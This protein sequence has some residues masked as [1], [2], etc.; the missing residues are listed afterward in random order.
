M[1]FKY[2]CHTCGKE[3]VGFPDLAFSAPRHYY[4]V[5]KEDRASQAVL[6][7]DTCVIRNEWFFVRGILPIPVHG[8]DDGFRY[9]VWVSLSRQR[10][11]RYQELFNESEPNEPPYFGWLA[12]RLRTYPDTE[13]LKTSMYLQPYPGRPVISFHPAEHPLVVEQRDGISQERL[14]EILEANL[15]PAPRS[16]SP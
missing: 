5:R 16:P 10:F 6:T 13:L 7:T 8:L 2:T 3:H 11:D 4:D 14:Q 9:G 12:N 1:G 15:H